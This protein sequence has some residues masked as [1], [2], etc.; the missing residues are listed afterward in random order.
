MNKKISIF[1]L[2]IVILA[3]SVEGARKRQATKNG[4]QRKNIIRATT[5]SKSTQPVE[6]PEETYVKIQEPEVVET[7]SEQT[8]SVEE[9]QQKIATLTT[10]NTVLNNE[11]KEK[12]TKFNDLTKKLS[13]IEENFSNLETQQNKSKST[14]RNILP[15]KID[16]IKEWLIAA[17]SASGVGTLAHATATTTS[18]LQK[19]EEQFNKKYEKDQLKNQNKFATIDGD[20]RPSAGGCA[21]K[22]D[23]KKITTKNKDEK[24]AKQQ[25]TNNVLETVS[26]V[27]TIVGT[28]ASAG[29]AISSSVATAL[30]NTI[31]K[32]VKDCKGSF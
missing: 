30:I 15:K 5:P 20:N 13:D 10:Q 17:V 25:K 4:P 14:C 29:T 24:W 26:N 7:S 18:F 31:T 11:I 12:Q 22:S 8:E 19:N 21:T 2:G 32:Q 6:L 3:N 16:E 9:M 23:N 1:L 27:S 28:V